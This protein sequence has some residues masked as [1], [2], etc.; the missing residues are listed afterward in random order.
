M[1]KNKDRYPKRRYWKVISLQRYSNIISNRN[2]AYKIQVFYPVKQWAKPL[3]EGSKLMVFSK[4]AAADKF[5]FLH[6][7]EIVPCL[8]KNPEVI[9]VDTKV[10]FCDSDF[11]DFTNYWRNRKVGI[12]ISTPLH[13]FTCVKPDTV[14]CDEVYCLE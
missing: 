11:S 7:G 8:V 9:S 5:K 6:G 1:G 12:P 3:I 13:L 2:D 4:K 14:F 10:L